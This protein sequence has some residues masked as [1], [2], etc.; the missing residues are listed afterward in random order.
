MA[1]AGHDVFVSE[2]GAPGDFACVYT[3]PAA[4]SV[5]LDKTKIKTAYEKLYVHESQLGKT[6]YQYDMFG[7]A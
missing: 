5:T 3:K 2:Y 6:L 1:A 7:A 4:N